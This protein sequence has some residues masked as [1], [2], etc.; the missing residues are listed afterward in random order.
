MLGVINLILLAG[1]IW[2]VRRAHGFKQNWVYI[3]ALLS[4]GLGALLF[5]ACSLMFLR[6]AIVGN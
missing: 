3:V 4:F 2:V 5:G 6:S 1:C